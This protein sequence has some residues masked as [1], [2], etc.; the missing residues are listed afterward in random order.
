MELIFIW[1][2]IIHV[3]RILMNWKCFLKHWEGPSLDPTYR[4]YVWTLLADLLFGAGILH[5]W[6]FICF[7]LTFYTCIIL[8]PSFISMYI[9]TLHCIYCTFQSRTL[10]CWLMLS[11]AT[12]TMNKVYLILSGLKDQVYYL[13]YLSCNIRSCVFSTYPNP[14]WWLWE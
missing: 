11:V 12:T 13:N 8:I 2:L 7:D 9:M 4:N 14:F 6:Y 3:I 5:G 1:F 10:A